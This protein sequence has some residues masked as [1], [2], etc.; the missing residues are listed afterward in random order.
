MNKDFIGGETFLHMK[1][2][3]Q[4]CRRTIQHS[5]SMLLSNHIKQYILFVFSIS[6]I[7]LVKFS[8]PAES[9]RVYRNSRRNSDSRDRHLP[10]RY[11]TAKPRLY[12]KS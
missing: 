4:M 12:K 11:N 3:Y 9:P 8:L 10:S 5:N 2:R 1:H 7:E 6:I